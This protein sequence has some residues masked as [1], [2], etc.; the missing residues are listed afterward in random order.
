MT[1]AKRSRSWVLAF[2]IAASLLAGIVVFFLLLP[3]YCTDTAPPDCW[4]ML[5]YGVPSGFG[6]SLAAA[7]LAAGL[8][9]VVLRRISRRR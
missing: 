5:G 2:T 6:L 9:G 8:V 4:S 7:A 1:P 3:Y